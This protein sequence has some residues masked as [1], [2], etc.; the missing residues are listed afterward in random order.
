MTT[1]TKTA[2]AGIGHNRQVIDYGEE[3]RGKLAEDYRDLN[4]KVTDLLNEARALPKKLEDEDAHNKSVAIVKKLRDELQNVEANRKKEK[5]PHLQRGRAVDSFFGDIKDRLD[6]AIDILLGR[7]RVYLDAKV[8]AE[9][10]AR[11]KA[12][13]AERKRAQE[14]QVRAAIEAAKA[15]NAKQIGKAL[16]HAANAQQFQAQAQ[17]AAQQAARSE[18]AA[19]ASVADL[20]RTRTD[21]GTST[22]RTEWKYEI[23][24]LDEIDLEKLRPYIAK[25]EIEKAIRL[26]IRAGGRELKGARI[27]ESTS[28]V[29][30]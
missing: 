22:L 13:E 7:I 28:A 10:I 27:F 24:A 20:A 17:V 16:K 4:L 14:A 1:A 2:P 18:A 23:T 15:E 30:R 9:R 5:D 6:K 26:Y 8:E 12:A 3:M 11:E 25:S 29:V 21:A 19:H